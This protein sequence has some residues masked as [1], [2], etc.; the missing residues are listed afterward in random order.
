MLPSPTLQLLQLLLPC[1]PRWGS[2]RCV[3]VPFPSTS[4][5]CCIDEP[6]HLLLL[7]FE[8]QDAG[9]FTRFLT[10]HE[11]VMMEGRNE[12]ADLVCRGFLVSSRSLLHLSE[13]LVISV[14]QATQINVLNASTVQISVIYP[15]SSLFPCLRAVLWEWG[16]NLLSQYTY[17]LSGE[18][19]NIPS[20]AT[21]AKGSEQRK[22]VFN[23][24]SVWIMHWLLSESMAGGGRVKR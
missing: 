1:T 18:K 24:V 17:S 23:C 6:V 10:K 7:L 22:S 4:H 8:L 14:C 16:T 19:K 5:A 11:S 20:F 21:V 15:A 12:Q 3:P 13:E 9:L 2:N